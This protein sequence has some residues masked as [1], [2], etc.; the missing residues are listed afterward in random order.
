MTSYLDPILVCDADQPRNPADGPQKGLR[1]CAHCGKDTLCPW[2]AA[3]R[4][5]CGLDCWEL[6]DFSL[7]PP[8]AGPDRLNGGL[9]D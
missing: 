9:F 2:D 4:V 6:A 3:G 5:F 1:P 7:A 8:V